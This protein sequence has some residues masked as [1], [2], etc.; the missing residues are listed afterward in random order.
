[1]ANGAGVSVL[2]ALA[3]LV[4]IHHRSDTKKKRQFQVVAS[5]PQELWGWL[6]FD[7]MNTPY[8][9]ENYMLNPEIMEV[10]G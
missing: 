4:C 3:C 8:T 9:L 2:C 10:D 1:V 7:R 5:R 6:I